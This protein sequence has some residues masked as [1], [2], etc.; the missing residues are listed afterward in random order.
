MP[1]G[2]VYQ[3][4]RGSIHTGSSH[5]W[6]TKQFSAEEQ[7]TLEPPAEEI[8]SYYASAVAGECKL[9]ANKMVT[10]GDIM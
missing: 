7:F 2:T 3:L 4:N 5:L 6:G 8:I 10:K 9:I 1:K